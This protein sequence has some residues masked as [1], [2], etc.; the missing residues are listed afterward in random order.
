MHVYEAI[1]S[2]E[3]GGAERALVE[4]L[5]WSP[6][7]VK[8]TVL[9]VQAGSRDLESRLASLGV[10]ILRFDSFA[11][12]WDWASVDARGRPSVAI[13]HTPRAAISM[14]IAR[15]KER[16]SM[17]VVV[18]HSTLLSDSPF[19][20][21]IVKPVMSRV[22][23]RADLHIAVSQAAADGPWCLN[24]RRTV[25]VPLGSTFDQASIPDT[26]DWP[27]GTKRRLVTIGR[28]S[29]P[30]NLMALLAAVSDLR[31]EF[32]A[33]GAHLLIVGDGPERK[34]LGLEIQRLSLT[35]AVS[36][37][38]PR[39]GIDSLL[40]GAHILVIPSRFE[41]GPL[42]VYEAALAGLPVATTPV[43]IVRE[44]VGQ[45]A[46]SLVAE[47]A[48]VQE[49]R[50]LLLFGLQTPDLDRSARLQ[51]ASMVTKWSSRVCARRFYEVLGEAGDCHWR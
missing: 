13:S 28:L 10:P 34:K 47:D 42:T 31:A 18:A 3:L 45:D 40:A 37:A 1:N 2:L 49:L 38:L 43:G 50:R 7:S 51:R 48:S 4:R 11:Q 29:E 36:L 19:R 20:S 6:D 27:K 21:R 8:T 23:G 32:K 33:S 44:V 5:R 39:V 16:R 30:K 41:G 14:L 24:A 46:L 15:R 9:S 17:R 26:T 25:V 12:A 35:A 22:N